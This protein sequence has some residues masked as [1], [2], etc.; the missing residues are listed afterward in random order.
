MDVHSPKN[1]INKYWSYPYH[2]WGHRSYHQSRTRNCSK[3]CRVAPSQ[4]PSPALVSYCFQVIAA[5]PT[6]QSPAWAGICRK[7]S[8]TAATITE[9][10]CKQVSFTLAAAGFFDFFF[11][12]CNLFLFSNPNFRLRPFFPGSE[13]PTWD[14]QT[15]D[16]SR[17]QC[18]CAQSLDCPPRLCGCWC[19]SFQFSWIIIIIVVIIITTCHFGELER[20][21]SQWRS[22]RSAQNDPAKQQRHISSLRITSSSPSSPPPPPSPSGPSS[23]T[24]T[25]TSSSGSVCTCFQFLTFLYMSVHFSNTLCPF[26]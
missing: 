5:N 23:S 2:L 18:H 13:D 8:G 26:A 3:Y 6:H 10:F 16:T 7:Q 12:Y 25:S 21:T 22:S 9:R 24:S 19:G 15:H 11:V 17:Y 20:G 14:H 4:R 1:G